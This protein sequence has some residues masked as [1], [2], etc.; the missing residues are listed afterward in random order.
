MLGAKG[1]IAAR[2]REIHPS[3]VYVWVF[4][5][6]YDAESK[7]F[8]LYRKFDDL[9]SNGN[10][11]QIAIFSDDVVNPRDWKFV[12]GMHIRINGRLNGKTDSVVTAIAIAARKAGATRIDALIDAHWEQIECH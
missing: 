4:D 11:P 10:H 9:I 3:G 6:P 12:Q 2:K 7:D 8:D 5:F 1:L